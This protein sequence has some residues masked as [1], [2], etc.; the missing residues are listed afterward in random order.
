MPRLIISIRELYDRE[1]RGRGQRMNSGLSMPRQPTSREND[2]VSVISFLDIS[3]AG[4]GQRLVV[5]GVGSESEPEELIPL[6]VLGRST[7]F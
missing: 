3:P 1:P 5:E 4:Q 2:A 6:E 7:S